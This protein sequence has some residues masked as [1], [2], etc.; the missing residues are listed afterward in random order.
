MAIRIFCHDM[1]ADPEHRRQCRAY[2]E[3][4]YRAAA[5]KLLDSEDPEG[6]RNLLRAG[7]FSQEETERLL[8]AAV[9]KGKT[10][11]VGVLLSANQVE[12][13][14][15]EAEQDRPLY[16]RI[17]ALLG[18]RFDRSRPYLGQIFHLLECR[19]SEE[20][21]GMGTDGF[22]FAVQ[23]KTLISRFAADGEGCQRDVAHVLAHRFL[24]HPLHAQAARDHGLWDLCSDCMA[25]WTLEQK[26]GYLREISEE[27]RTR[28]EKAYEWLKQQEIVSAAELYRR[29]SNLPEDI[30]RGL[31][32]AFCCDDHHLWYV[33]VHSAEEWRGQI[34]RQKRLSGAGAG[35]GVLGGIR[36]SAGH[37]VKKYRDPEASEYDYQAFLERFM[38]SGEERMVDADNSDPILYHYSRC[39]Y[40]GLVLL[41]PLETREVRRLSELVIAIDTSGSCSGEIVQQFLR[42]TF[43]ILEKKER[44]FRRMRVHILQCDSM[45]QEYHLIESEQDWQQ[46][47]KNVKI[48]GFGN[49]DFRPVFAWIEEN[50]QNGTVRDLKGLIYFTDG[51]GIY[52]QK[53]P[54]YET[55]FVYLNDRLRKGKT[56]DYVR[57]LNLHLDRAFA[58]LFDEESRFGYCGGKR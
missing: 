28:R 52:P 43:T 35:E 34:H 36:G 29:F 7:F 33:S 48:T 9:K 24:F 38:V 27:E 11:C 23:E 18:R 51:D 56:P 3:R 31:A 5:E 15:G 17:L 13:P 45:I 37:A 19:V 58:N 57:S 20:I 50:R 1:D 46:Y 25:E 49:T 10:D 40:D 32:Q 44:F 30:R 12:R 6:L 2:L 8:C 21:C 42:E 47:R 16:E 55:A 39:H 26:L 22:S 41:E 54:D 4:R 53:A 14:S